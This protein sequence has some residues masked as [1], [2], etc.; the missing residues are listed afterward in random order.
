M[1]IPRGIALFQW[2]KEVEEVFIDP[3]VFFLLTLEAKALA[4][5]RWWVD[6]EGI[7]DGG[8]F[9][10]VLTPQSESLNNPRSS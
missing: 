5:L 9:S 6:G 1:K 7:K 3:R 8:T 4:R 2:T 10:I